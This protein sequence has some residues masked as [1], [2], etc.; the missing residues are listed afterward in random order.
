MYGTNRLENKWNINGALSWDLLQELPDCSSGDS[1]HDDGVMMEGRVSEEE[2]SPQ[3]DAE[4]CR[5]FIVTFLGPA[6]LETCWEW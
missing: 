1:G 2:R 5:G 6:T 4:V 3:C